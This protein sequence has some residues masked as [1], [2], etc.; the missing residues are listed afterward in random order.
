MVTGAELPPLCSNQEISC[1]SG[2]CVPISARCNGYEDC[3]DGSDERSCGSNFLFDFIFHSIFIQFLGCNLGEHR[4]DSGEC[5]DKSFICNGI[6]DC[7]NDN[8]D[9]RNCPAPG[10]IPVPSPQPAGCRADTQIVCPDLKTRICEVERCDGVENC[11][12]NP[13][14][15]KAWDEEGCIPFNN[16]TFEPPKSTTVSTTSSTTTT[17]LPRNFFP[18]ILVK[19]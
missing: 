7:P 6:V 13:G 9:E 5:V 1:H 10:I 16:V 18:R 2:E 8:S 11:P 14:E 15:E 4:C 12:K 3:S 19:N 17:T